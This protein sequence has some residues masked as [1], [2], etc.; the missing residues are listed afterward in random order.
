[1]AALNALALEEEGT[2]DREDFAGLGTKQAEA[3]V[4]TT[5]AEKV[6]QKN[7]VRRDNPKIS[8]EKAVKEAERRSR[9]IGK[10]ISRKLKSG[11]A[12]YRQTPETARKVAEEKSYSPKGGLPDP[13][14]LT[15]TVGGILER[16]LRSEEEFTL[17]VESLI[18]HKDQLEPHEQRRLF[19]ALTVVSNRALNLLDRLGF[20]ADEQ[21]N[22]DIIDVGVVQ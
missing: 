3:L 10:E 22:G 12:G 6:R 1:V 7:L 11:E 2:L 19:D 20:Q 16:F 21:D 4:K 8:E 18:K 15:K 14:G 9:E 17:K 13:S 5:R